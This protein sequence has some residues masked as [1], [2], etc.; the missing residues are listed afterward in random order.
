MFGSKQGLRLSLQ[1]VLASGVAFLIALAALRPPQVYGG[2]NAQK[3]LT[4]AQ[5]IA[6]KIPPQTSNE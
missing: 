3:F 6:V 1:L 5:S 2:H 4:A